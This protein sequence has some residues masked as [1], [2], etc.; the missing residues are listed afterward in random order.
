MK[1]PNLPSTLSGVPLMAI[2][3]NLVRFLHYS[4]ESVPI[5]ELTWIMSLEFR[6]KHGKMV[7]VMGWWVGG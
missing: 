6:V 2:S 3:P 1:A 4:L 7:V 5:G